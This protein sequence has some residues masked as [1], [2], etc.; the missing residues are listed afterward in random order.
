VSSR[1]AAA[2]I[3]NVRTIV[4]VL[5]K[6]SIVAAAVCLFEIGQTLKQREGATLPQT[7]EILTDLPVLEKIEHTRKEYDIIIS[8][9]ILGKPEKAASPVSAAAPSQLKLRLVGTH[10]GNAASPLAIIEDTGKKT[11]DVFEIDEQIFGQARLL[12]VGKDSIK[13]DHNGKP[14]ILYMEELKG[15]S[16]GVTRDDSESDDGELEYSVSQEELDSALANLP[17]LLSQARAVPYFKEGKSIGMR[18]FAI[19]QGS[20]Y[21]KLG[22]KNGDIIKNV[23]DNELSDPAQALK[24]FEELKTER[25]IYVDVERNGVDVELSYSIR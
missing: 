6:L 9:G 19:R 17:Q 1:I 5:G 22:L 10:I 13:V 23:N 21:E 4:S 18:L 15:G 3:I 16:D 2:E 11:Q 12:E 8:R 7:A 25:S 24:L 20:L 14:E